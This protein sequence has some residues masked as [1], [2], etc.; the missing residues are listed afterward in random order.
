METVWGKWRGYNHVHG[1]ESHEKGAKHACLHDG[2]LLMLSLLL[3]AIMASG[4]AFR[5]GWALFW[6]WE[7]GAYGLDSCCDTKLLPSSIGM[8]QSSGV[9]V[10]YGHR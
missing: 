2:F 8:V 9:W 3:N 5:T 7:L 10:T 4:Q 1:R 6:G